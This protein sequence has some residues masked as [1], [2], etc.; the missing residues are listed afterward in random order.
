MGVAAN[1]IR[2]QRLHAMKAYVLEKSGILKYSSTW[3]MIHDHGS[4]RWEQLWPE[5]VR[6]FPIMEE[7]GEALFVQGG[8][9]SPREQKLIGQGLHEWTIR[10]K[11][12]PEAHV[13]HH[14]IFCRQPFVDLL[15]DFDC[16]HL[17]VIPIETQLVDQKDDPMVDE[18]TFFVPVSNFI[19]GII[20]EKTSVLRR[21][22]A[23]KRDHIVMSSVQIIGKSPDAVTVSGDSI[24]GQVL[25]RDTRARASIFCSEE[26]FAEFKKRKLRALKFWEVTV[27]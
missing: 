26:F 13:E 18:P 19:D 10:T 22:K 4:D 27:E 20:P 2:R 9:F 7:G 6:E 25:W 16:S 11:D 3:G 1:G 24:R 23:P 12:L 5:G 17:D 14:G 15:N 21:R 8:P